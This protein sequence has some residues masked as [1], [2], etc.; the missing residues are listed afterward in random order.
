MADIITHRAHF[1]Q[2]KWIAGSALLGAARVVT[3][4]L[5]YLLQELHNPG[6][7]CM[8]VPGVSPLITDFE[9][10]PF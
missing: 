6:N 5:L 2:F 8:G 4:C 9:L 3:C 10:D 1:H 7:V